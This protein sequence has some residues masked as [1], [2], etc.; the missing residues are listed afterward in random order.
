MRRFLVGILLMFPASSWS[1]QICESLISYKWHKADSKDH[2][3]VEWE[4]VS[5]SGSDE[6]QAKAA[7]QETILKSKAQALEACRKDHE[8]V[9][10]CLAA[11]YTG[12]ATIINSLRFEAR[13]A[14][15]QAILSD[16]S[17]QQGICAAVEASEVKCEEK[18]DASHTPGAGE[19]EKGSE[20]EKGKKK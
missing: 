2:L 18:V 17:Q 16:C 5:A 3:L 12:K 1:E 9:A 13:K 7:L 15:E 10:D 4:H 19:G 8:S 14:M 11:K 6:K 20:K